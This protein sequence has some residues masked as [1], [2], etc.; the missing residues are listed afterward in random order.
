MKYNISS[1]GILERDDEILFIEYEDT[2]GKY[3][4]LPGGTQD[5]GESLTSTVIREF[6]EETLLDIK[7]KEFFMLR[8]FILEKSDIKTWEEGIH[9]VEAIFICE[10]IDKNQEDGIG[11]IP[12]GGMLGLKWINKKDFKNYRLYPTQNLPELLEKR[13]ISYMFTNS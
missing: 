6:K 2:I 4:S 11:L 8:E 1:R 10:I 13:N 5:K 9:Q 7:V 3:Y 12:D